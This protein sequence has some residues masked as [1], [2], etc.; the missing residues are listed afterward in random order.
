MDVCR[1]VLRTDLVVAMCLQVIT[2]SLR[3]GETASAV[4]TRVR[5]FSSVQ[6]LMAVECVRPTKRPGAVLALERL[7]LETWRTMVLLVCA[8]KFY[9][10]SPYISRKEDRL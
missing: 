6:S 7:L 5:L 9:R 1:Y 10:S 2:E 8:Q 3:L 4:F